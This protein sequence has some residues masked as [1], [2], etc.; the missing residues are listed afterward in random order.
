MDLTSCCLATLIARF[1]GKKKE[2]AVCSE[3]VLRIGLLFVP[4]VVSAEACNWSEHK[5]EKL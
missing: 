4:K 5:E 3:L 2:G 1:A